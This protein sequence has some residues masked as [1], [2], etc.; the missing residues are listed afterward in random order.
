M[1]LQAFVEIYLGMVVIL[2]IHPTILPQCTPPNRIHPAAY[3]V[4]SAGLLGRMLIEKNITT[5]CETKENAT[6]SVSVKSEIMSVVAILG[7]AEM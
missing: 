2:D 3:T 6:G 7:V 1:I 4:I 5:A